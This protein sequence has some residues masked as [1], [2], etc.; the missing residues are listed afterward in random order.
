MNRPTLGEWIAGACVVL[1]P[2]AFLPLWRL[3]EMIG[4]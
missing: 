2:F 1:W 4:G 3:L